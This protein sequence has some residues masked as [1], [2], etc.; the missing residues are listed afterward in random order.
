MESRNRY[1]FDRNTKLIFANAF[2]KVGLARLRS[3]NLA[4]FC[5]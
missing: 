5:A 2:G 1:S 4:H 3:F